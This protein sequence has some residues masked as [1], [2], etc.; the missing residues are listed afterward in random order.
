LET[1]EVTILYTWAFT[2]K[3]VKELQSRIY[4]SCHRFFKILYSSSKLHSLPAFFI[5]ATKM[6]ES[7]K[8]YV[9]KHC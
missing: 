8:F 7:L 1:G 6:H 2:E 9:L 3:Y 4:S 5:Y